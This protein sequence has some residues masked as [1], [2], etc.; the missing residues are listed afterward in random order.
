M[1]VLRCTNAANKARWYCSLRGSCVQCVNEGSFRHVPLPH[2]RTSASTSLFQNSGVRTLISMHSQDRQQITITFT[3]ARHP[4][5]Q[6][7]LTTLAKDLCF[8]L[9]KRPWGLIALAS[10]HSKDLLKL[11]LRQC[12]YDN[13]TLNATLCSRIFLGM[14]R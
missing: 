11:C 6:V 5:A 7:D 1:T 12:L 10:R 14:R 3:S 13:D 4:D 9:A 2:S 8:Y